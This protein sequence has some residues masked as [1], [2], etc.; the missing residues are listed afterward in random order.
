MTTST[1]QGDQRPKPRAYLGFDLGHGDTSLAWLPAHLSNENKRR[2]GYP[3]MIKLVGDEAAWMTAYGENADGSKGVLGTPACADALRLPD[4]QVHYRFKRPPD[5]CSN[6]RRHLRAYA[7]LVIGAIQERKDYAVEQIVCVGCPSGWSHDTLTHYQDLLQG[8]HS[9]VVGLRVL[10]ESR[11]AMLQAI[12]ESNLTSNESV[13]SDAI[14]IDVGSSTTDFTL[15]ADG[16]TRFVDQGVTI[17]AGL[18]DQAIVDHAELWLSDKGLASTIRELDGKPRV[19]LLAAARQAKERYFT[20]FFRTANGSWQPC[21]HDLK[22]SIAD[23]ASDRFHITL[24]ADRHI[25]VTCALDYATMT[26]ILEAPIAELG[27]RSWPTA[28]RD[29]LAEVRDSFIA[30]GASPKHVILV[31]GG[32]MMDFVQQIAREVFAD[33]SFPSCSNPRTFIA[34]GL[35]LAAERAELAERFKV[36]MTTAMDELGGASSTESE[37][38]ESEIARLTELKDACVRASDYEG[39][40]SLREQ[41]DAL[42]KKQETL[43]PA[44][45][46]KESCLLDRLFERYKQRLSDAFATE[47]FADAILVELDFWMRGINDS[48]EKT[49]RDIKDRIRK[50]AAGDRPR[51]IWKQHTDQLFKDIKSEWCTLE[52]V[53]AACTHFGIQPK[54]FASAVASAPIA[55]PDDA[56]PSS[57][58]EATAFIEQVEGITSDVIGAMAAILVAVITVMKASLLLMGPVGWAVIALLAL[59]GRA[60]AVWVLRTQSLPLFLRN[61]MMDEA[62]LA[63]LKRE[64]VPKVSRSIRASFATDVDAIRP[65][66][67]KAI[68][69]CVNSQI[70]LQLKYVR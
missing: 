8:I 44:V 14:V 1:A 9:R 10:R 38:I 4:N 68:R 45:S 56:M 62:R 43:R 48:I 25:K 58:G 59:A 24:T 63:E 2:G 31:G 22:Q 19:A 66:I 15:I 29:A 27:Q 12:T 23:G 3:E 67:R 34:R 49:E 6:A 16:A 57:I 60:G 17:G 42:K 65:R 5:S 61:W 26:Q 36:D 50:W 28:F 32:A 35:A 39:A 30:Q 69:E 7:E 70:E 20:S 33:A 21:P 51:A 40:A 47:M 37:E 41:V 46:G 13:L 11:A 64:I 18:I 54:E 52:S 55:L 53:S